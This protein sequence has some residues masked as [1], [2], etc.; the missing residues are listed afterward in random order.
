MQVKLSLPDELVVELDRMRGDVTRSRFV[1][2][3]VESVGGEPTILAHVK[4]PSPVVE[5]SLE[6][7]EDSEVPRGVRSGDDPLPRVF[8]VSDAL[9]TGVVTPPP[10]RHSPTCSCGVCKPVKS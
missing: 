2:R 1:Q 4:T 6:P 3:L 9:S 5:R 10:R 8:G 7:Q